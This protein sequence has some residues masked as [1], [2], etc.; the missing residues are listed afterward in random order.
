MREVWC[1]ILGNTVSYRCLFTVFL[2]FVVVYLLFVLWIRHS[3][4][5]LDQPIE[6]INFG[7]LV[8]Y[9]NYRGLWCMPGDFLEV[10]KV[11]ALYW[12]FLK[13][14]VQLPLLAFTSFFVRL[15]NSESSIYKS[16]WCRGKVLACHF[17]VLSSIPNILTFTNIFSIFIV[18]WMN[19]TLIGDW[20]KYV[21]EKSQYFQFWPCTFHFF[22]NFFF[23]ENSFFFDIVEHIFKHIE[24]L[25][26][27]L[28]LF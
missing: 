6:L 21:Q 2:L 16:V 22:L 18:C 3:Q 20:V 28:N 11:K 5:E 15:P 23:L 27:I 19:Q 1:V 14:L 25:E 12:L 10:E 24:N 4:L 9:F 7:T 17:V 13:L 26:K 8:P